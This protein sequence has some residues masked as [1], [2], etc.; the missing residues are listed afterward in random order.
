MTAPKKQTRKQLEKELREAQEADQLKFEKAYQAI[1]EKH[2]LRLVPVAQPV[3]QGG[4]QITIGAALS[5]EPYE[6]PKKEPEQ[7]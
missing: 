6:K 1:C 7:E 2:G 3:A 4:G 5:I